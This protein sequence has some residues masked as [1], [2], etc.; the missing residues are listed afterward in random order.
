MAAS[1]SNEYGTATI[2]AFGANR[3]CI[4][5]PEDSRYCLKYERPLRERTPVG[6]REALRRRLGF[7]FPMFGDNR[8]E[9]R[10][11]RRLRERLGAAPDGVVA[12]CHGIVVTAHGPALRCDCAIGADGAP[13]PSLYRCLFGDDANDR[14]HGADALCSAVDRLEA[15]L[16]KHHVPLFDLN[17]GNFVVVENRSDDGATRLDLICVDLKSMISSKEILPI[18]RWIPPLMRRK[19]QRRAE[20]LRQRIREARASSPKTASG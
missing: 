14:R 20:R 18:S 1:S 10:A 19:I 7:W 8:S 17:S 3:V 5:D 6:A 11:Y 12:A 16:L 9:L 4:V 13:A 15:W 2:L